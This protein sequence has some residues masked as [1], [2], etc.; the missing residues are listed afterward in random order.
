MFLKGAG[1]SPN[2]YRSYLQA[3]KQFYVF[4][5]GKHPFQVGPADVEAFYDDILGR[6]DMSTAYLRLMGLKRFFAGIRAVLPIY[7]SPFE[8]MSEKL[9]HKISRSKRKGRTKAPLT[10]TEADALLRWLR[11]D[12]SP[13]GRE[14]LALVVMLQT[15]G[16][17][18][19]ELC[20]HSE[21]R[22]AD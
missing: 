14:N 16:L 7:T 17:R 4:T 10:K 20:S 21:E 11:M 9:L 13:T 15:S 3:V 19:S 1:L 18:A 12:V 8:S 5:G 2:T 22:P 6:A